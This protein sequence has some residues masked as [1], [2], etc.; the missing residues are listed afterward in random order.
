MQLWPRK[1][2]PV[3]N[4]TRN[5]NF[6]LQTLDE[7]AAIILLGPSKVMAKI[8]IHSLIRP[9]RTSAR[10]QST[11]TSLYYMFQCFQ[12]LLLPCVIKEWHNLDP[13]V[14]KFISFIFSEAV[15]NIIRSKKFGIILLTRLRL[16]FSHLGK[17]K[18]QNG[19]YKKTKHAKC[20]K[21]TFLTP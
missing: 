11:F 2:H 19:C 17:H 18:F 3:S 10:R 12:T 15:I 5:Q 8:F 13:N 20:S 1:D 21:K 16:G 14:R 9:I 7:T 6:E 4:S